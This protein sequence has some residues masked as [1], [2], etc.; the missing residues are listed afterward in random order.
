MVICVG[1]MERINQRGARSGDAIYPTHKVAD[2]PA[3]LQL[4]KALQQAIPE[5]KENKDG[6]TK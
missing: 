2:A 5:P 6:D 4:A 1:Y 3:I